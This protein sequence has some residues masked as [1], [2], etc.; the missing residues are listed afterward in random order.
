MTHEQMVVEILAIVVP[1]MI[2]GLLVVGLLD[3]DL[4]WWRRKGYTG[5]RIG[6]GSRRIRKVRSPKRK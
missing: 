6:S 4:A 5:G 2:C 1:G 3:L